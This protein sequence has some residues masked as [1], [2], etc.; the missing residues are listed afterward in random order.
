LLFSPHSVPTESCAVLVTTTSCRFLEQLCSNCL[1]FKPTFP[2]S[3]PHPHC[4]ASRLATVPSA[5]KL[6]QAAMSELPVRALEHEYGKSVAM[7]VVGPAG[8]MS[9]QTG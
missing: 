9:A 3:T 2:L 8:R 7:V 4:R 5:L 6:S 1:S